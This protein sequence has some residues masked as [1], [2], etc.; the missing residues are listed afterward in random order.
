MQDLI[1]SFET[2]PK[3]IPFVACYRLYY[4]EVLL[5][6]FIV[7]MDTDMYA[8]RHFLP[9]LIG[10]AT[11]DLNH[12]LIYGVHDLWAERGY[13]PQLN[14]TLSRYINSGFFL[15]RNNAEGKALMRQARS[16]VVQNFKA[17]N[18]TDQDAVNMALHL[19]P[20]ALFLLP[21][22][23][24]CFYAWCWDHNLSGQAIH[25]RKGASLFNVL[26]K[27]YADKC[28]AKSIINPN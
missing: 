8:G 4:T 10:I 22:H 13:R 5:Q 17:A 20:S 15:I 16:L 25:H 11:T 9:E 2:T 19:N 18:L 27:E 12:S 7:S 1:P 23:F 6:D 28:V 24:N 14:L 26:R 3:D 21:G